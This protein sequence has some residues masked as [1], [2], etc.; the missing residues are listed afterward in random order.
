MSKERE[1]DLWQLGRIN[2]VSDTQRDS[3]GLETCCEKLPFYI[4][5]IEVKKNTLH[6]YQG[7]LITKMNVN[8]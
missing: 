5:L 8:H 1:V 3:E 7:L 2:M 6:Y 4:G